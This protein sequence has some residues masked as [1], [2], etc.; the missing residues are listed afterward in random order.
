VKEVMT[1][2]DAA[3]KEALFS[4]EATTDVNAVLNEALSLMLSSGLKTL[5]VV[6]ED[7]K[8]VG[9]LTFDAIQEALHEAVKTGGTK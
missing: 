3:V 2:P 6:G 1:V 7:N 8:L 9:I 4:S 5:P